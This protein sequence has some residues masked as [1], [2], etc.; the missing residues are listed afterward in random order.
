MRKFTLFASLFIAS[1]CFASTNA[2]LPNLDDPEVRKKII[3]QGVELEEV[4]KAD[5]TKQYSE[6]LRI[7]AYTGTGWGV[8]YDKERR[9]RAISQFRKGKQHG[10]VKTWHDNGRKYI[11]GF[12]KD[13]RQHGLTSL[14]NKGGQLLETCN[15]KNGKRDGLERKWYENGNKKIECVWLD[16]ERNG[17]YLQWYENGN[18]KAEAL[19]KNGVY[20]G[21]LITWHENGS[22]H[23]ESQWDSG[24]QEGLSTFWY[25]NG[26]KEQEGNW[27]NGKQDG[28]AV[29]WHT[30]GKKR[31][32]KATKME[33]SRVL[34]SHGM[35]TGVR[36]LSAILSR[37]KGMGFPRSGTPM[38]S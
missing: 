22:R 38:A 14:W 8:F 36:S 2:D 9:V 32:K 34:P 3:E 31:V 12:F 23:A 17:T 30:N 10:L 13:N 19:M 21:R 5:G 11:E 1:L 35:L 33:M 6:P 28:L 18:S 27:K 20:H 7:S 4:A 25:E 15:W 24:R 26:Q 37:A 16:G 29:A